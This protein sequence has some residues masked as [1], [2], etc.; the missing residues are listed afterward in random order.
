MFFTKKAKKELTDDIV[1][2]VDDY[3]K[4]IVNKKISA[5]TEEINSLT[6]RLEKYDKMFEDYESLSLEKALAKKSN[7]PWAGLSVS[8]VDNENGRVGIELDW[9]EQFI[10]YLRKNGINGHTDE[11]TMG[12][13]FASLIKEMGSEISEEEA[14]ALRKTHK[15]Y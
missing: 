14:E 9:N 5:M 1:E 11:D 2:K 15:L 6:E 12:I 7:E 13:W 8:E 10:N 4:Q 3:L